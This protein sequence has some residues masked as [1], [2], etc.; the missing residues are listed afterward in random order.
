MKPEEALK[1]L[2]ECVAQ[3]QASGA[4]HDVL[5]ESLEV[6]GK[7]V[8]EHGRARTGTDKDKK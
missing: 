4:V 2:R 6:L 3:V 7:L 5:R 1:N 8:D